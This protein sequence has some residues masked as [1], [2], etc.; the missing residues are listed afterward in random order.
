MKDIVN[1]F[2][3]HDAQ[4]ANINID[5]SSPG[6]IDSIELKVI[7][8]DGRHSIVTF[9]DCYAARFELNFGIIANESILDFSIHP[10]EP[11]LQETRSIW[12]QMGVALTDL[13][14]ARIETSSTASV[15]LICFKSIKVTDPE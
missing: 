9:D 3:W 2:Q 5:R 7:W 15:L 14:C 8:P 12:L 6:L 10:E 13:I 4:I 1:R 11:L